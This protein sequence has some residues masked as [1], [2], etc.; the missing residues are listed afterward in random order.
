MRRIVHFGLALIS[1]GATM[2]PLHA[3]IISETISAS[4]SN[5]S[6]LG[7][8]VLP[9]VDPA[10]ISFSI[11]FDNSVAV[12]NQTGGLALISSNLPLGSGF[13]FTYR[14][15]TDVLAV[16]GLQGNVVGGSAGTDDYSWAFANISTTPTIFDMFYAV[17]SDPVS[18]FTSTT[19]TVTASPLSAAVPEPA[20]VAL[21]AVG[22]GGLFM[23]RRRRR[24]I[25]T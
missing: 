20:S 6:V 8:A 12:E 19:G 25:A 21:L 10:K 3:T 23:V 15:G 24:N 17:S 4:V 2:R 13:G 18:L 14:L 16:G 11:T 7:T 5:F 22:L 1:V 9:P